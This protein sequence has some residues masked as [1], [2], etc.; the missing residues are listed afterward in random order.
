MKACEGTAMARPDPRDRL[1]RGD[2][3]RLDGATGSELQRRGI[4]VSRGVSAEGA[5]G[6][7]S[8]TAMEDAPAVVRAIHED[9]LRVG[10]EVVTTNSYNTNRGQLARV[11]LAH[12]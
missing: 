1:A 8:G 12:R 5:L 3:L 7:W 4:N 2:R 6:A 9:Y 10:A 11:G